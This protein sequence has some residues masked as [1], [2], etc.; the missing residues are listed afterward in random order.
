MTMCIYYGQALLLDAA[1][2]ETYSSDHEPEEPHSLAFASQS[3]A[4]PR[5]SGVHKGGFSKGGFCNLCVII[6]MFVLLN[7]PLLNTSL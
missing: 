3:A 1:R 2:C 6:I 5:R 4:A 7:P